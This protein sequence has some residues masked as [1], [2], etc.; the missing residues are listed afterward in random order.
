[1]NRYLLIFSGV[2]SLL[3]FSCHKIDLGNNDNINDATKIKASLFTPVRSWFKLRSIAGTSKYARSSTIY[4]DSADIA[5]DS[6]NN[7]IVIKR[8]YGTNYSDSA[9]ET[10]SYNSD[11]QLTLYECTKNYDQLYISRMEFQ[12]DSIG[13]VTKVVSGYQNS[14]IATSEGPVTYVKRGDTTFITYL[15]SAKKHLQ[16]YYDGQDF[17]TVALLNGKL[18]ARTDFPI[19]NKQSD[20]SQFKYEYDGAG[21]LV[22]YTQQ[23]GIS[24]PT[25]YTY[26]RGS[27]AAQD[28][29]K[30]VDQWTGDL[31]WFT[32]AKFFFPLQEIGYDNS[33][34]GNVVQSIQKNTA[35]ITFTNAFDTNGNL[36]STSYTEP[37]PY[38]ALG[39][40]TKTEKYRY[41]P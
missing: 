36:I 32:R 25:V 11:Y 41:W 22:T 31:F 6:V 21:N 26:Q 23:Y 37:P 19:Y 39:A 13:Q 18:I 14:L 34:L 4:K 15:D 12:R 27:Q 30:F 20:T 33:I 16:S 38:S 1:M 7:K 10:Y 29:Q 8:Y 28:L 5:I 24:T 3:L 40:P 2:I 17:Y 35:T 9:T